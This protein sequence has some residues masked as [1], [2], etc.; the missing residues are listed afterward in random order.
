MPVPKWVLVTA[1]RSQR[2]LATNRA[3]WSI[4]DLHIPVRRHELESRG[5][6]SRWQDLSG[7]NSS[8][9]AIF[10]GDTEC[11]V[12]TLKAM[13]VTLVTAQVFNCLLFVGTSDWAKLK[14]LGQRVERKRALLSFSCFEIASVWLCCMFLNLDLFETF[15]S[16]T[17]KK[18]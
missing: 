10:Q 18:T 2:S 1:L 9:L 7:V 15:C 17:A 5:F 3:T 6:E 4:R 14:F 12:A 11:Y 13:L 8:T 16:L